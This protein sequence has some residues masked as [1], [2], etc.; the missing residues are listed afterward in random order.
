MYDA[1]ETVRTDIKGLETTLKTP[2]A[3]ERVARIAQAFEQCAQDVSD[4][5]RR[6]LQEDERAA[7][8]KI[9]RGMVAARRMMLRLHELAGMES[10]GL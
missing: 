7:L 10:S 2:D 9:Y 1:L 4:A 3:K 5:T 8:Q 6:A